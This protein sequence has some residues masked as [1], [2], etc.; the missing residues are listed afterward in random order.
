MDL[1]WTDQRALT[2]Q[3]EQQTNGGD[4]ELRYEGPDQS[5]VRTGLSQG[6]HVFRVRSIDSEGQASAWT[7]IRIQV[8]YMEPAR[9]RLLLITGG[10]VVLA[11]ISVIIFGHLNHRKEESA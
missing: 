5:S 8:E 7:D 4:F 2:Y 9:V 3:L 11:T 10:I 1:K 6:D